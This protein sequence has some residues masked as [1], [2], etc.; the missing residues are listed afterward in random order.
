[1]FFPFTI[2]TT[3]SK[4]GHFLFR[5]LLFTIRRDITG[6]FVFTFTGQEHVGGAQA[7]WFFP[8]NLSLVLP[9][10]EQRLSERVFFSLAF[11]C[12]QSDRFWKV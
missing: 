11:H 5:L 7:P 12:N 9:G 6:L 4:L 3:E 2:R 8:V 1:V 10:R